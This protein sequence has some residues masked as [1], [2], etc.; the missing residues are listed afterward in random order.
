MKRFRICVLL[1]D[2]RVESF[3]RV[4]GLFENGEKIK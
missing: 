2:V 3:K 4:T 1:E